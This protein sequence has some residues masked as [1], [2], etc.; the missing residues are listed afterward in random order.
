MMNY[1]D[2]NT[3]TYY[4]TLE[5]EDYSNYIHKTRHFFTVYV[6]MTKYISYHQYYLSCK[7]DRIRYLV[8]VPEVLAVFE[9]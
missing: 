5:Y 6:R 4:L 3:F 1:D 7:V 9:V 2:R 8:L